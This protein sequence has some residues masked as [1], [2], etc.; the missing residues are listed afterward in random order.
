MAASESHPE[1]PLE[2]ERVGFLRRLW[3]FFGPLLV[4]AAVLGVIY[5]LT[6]AWTL[7]EVWITGLVSLLGAGT[8]VVFGKAALG[9]MTFDLKLGTW[10]L[11]YIVM[12]VNGV[13]GWFY[14]YNLDLLEKLPKMGTWLRLSLIHI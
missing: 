13:S 1:P 14:T 9:D 2:D 12:Y 11:A 3:Y 8:T 4:T 7:H 5:L 6:D 10:Q